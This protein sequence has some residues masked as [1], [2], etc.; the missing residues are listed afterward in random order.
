MSALRLTRRIGC[1][2]TGGDHETQSAEVWHVAKLQ[3]ESR[4]QAM[5]HSGHLEIA[6]DLPDLAALKAELQN[7][8]VNFT[9][10]GNMTLAARIGAH[11]DL[12][13]AVAIALWYAE[14]RTRTNWTQE[15]F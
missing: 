14:H 9:A 13:L 10:I 2:I 6:A 11:D 5:L 15:D 4:L 12:V 7:F 3:P 1:S 8:R